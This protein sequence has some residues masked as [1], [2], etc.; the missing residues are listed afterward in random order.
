MRAAFVVCETTQGHPERQRP[1]PRRQHRERGSTRPPD[2]PKQTKKPSCSMSMRV[3]P[4]PRPIRSRPRRK[5]A[6]SPASQIPASLTSSPRG[7]NRFRNCPMACAPPIGTTEIRSARRSRPRRSARAS[8]AHRS[9]SPSTNTTA[10]GTPPSATARLAA[11]SAASAASESDRGFSSTSR[12]LADAGGVAGAELCRS[13]HVALERR[14]R[15]RPAGRWPPA[16]P[17]RTS[18]AMTPAPRCASTSPLATVGGAADA[19]LSR[20]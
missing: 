14:G 17:W 10:R 12:I 20:R 9:L 4:E 11:T 8:N 6:S 16:R 19:P 15:R 2:P 13:A 1:A 18:Y 7:P 5:S 3:S